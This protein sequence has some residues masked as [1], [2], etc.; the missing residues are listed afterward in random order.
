MVEKVAELGFDCIELGTGAYPGNAHCNPTELLADRAALREFRGQL[1]EAGLSISGLSCHGNPLHPD[2]RIARRHRAEFEQTVRLA[3]RLEVPVVNVLSGCPGDSPQAK[4][5]NWITCA[6]PPEYPEAL[7]WQWREVVVPYWK[8]AAAFAHKHGIERIAVEMHPGFV[9]YNPETAM[10]LRELVGP[11][12]GVNFDPSHLFWLGVDIRAAIRRLG[13]AIFHCHA[14]DT[15]IDQRNVS[16]NGVLSPL[17]YDLVQQRPWTFRTVGWGH[18]L[19][20]WREIVTELRLVGYDHVMSIEHEDPL[21]S[22]DE[23][24]RSAKEFLSAAI[25]RDEPPKAWWI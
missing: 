5:P 12:I 20:C 7:E 8:Q 15:Y 17:S 10:R 21:A 18:D 13:D 25:L 16:E 19:A 24:L 1:K 14:K 6:W 11:R 23:G 9:V 3:Q 4:C 22:V 2:K